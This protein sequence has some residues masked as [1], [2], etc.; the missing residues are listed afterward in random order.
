MRRV[1]C[2]YK[3]VGPVIIADDPALAVDAVNGQNTLLECLAVV[4]DRFRRERIVVVLLVVVGLILTC[5]A[6][7]SACRA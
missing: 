4:L 7:A 5:C 2:S 6:V 1:P 3:V